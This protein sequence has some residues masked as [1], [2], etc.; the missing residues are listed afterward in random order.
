[1]E[2]RERNARQLKK[3]LAAIPAHAT[4]A[5][6]SVAFLSSAVDDATLAQTLVA[7]ANN[8]GGTIIIGVTQKGNLQNIARPE[9]HLDRVM[10]LA[11]ACDPPLI[12]P[13]P[14]VH[15]MKNRPLIVIS[16]PAD[17]PHVYNADGRYVIWENGDIAPLK[18]AALRQ[19]IFSRGETGF[20]AQIAAR[21][22]PANLNWDAVRAYVDSVPGLRHLSAEEALLKRGCLKEDG[23]HLRPTHAGLLL[24]AHDPQT[25]FSQAE[26][27]IARY[28]G[29]Q[30]TDSFL[31]ADIHGTLPEQAR[32]A[33]AFLRENIPQ[34]V[35]IAELQRTD[36]YLYPLSAV[37]EVIVN[38]LAHRDYSISGDN[39]RILMFSDRLECYSPGRLPGHVTVTNI[40][41]ERFSRNATIVQ[42]LY[43]MGFIERLGYGIDRIV[44]SIAE[45]GMPQPQF[46]ETAAG[47]KITLFAPSAAPAQKLPPVREW[48]KMGL[49]ERQ[50][51]AIGFVA[52]NG[53]I[54]NANYQTL[55]PAVSPETLRRDLADL[56]ARDILLRIG[57]KRA[58]FYI[59]K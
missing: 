10:R 48:L 20:D 4:D 23:G 5:V 49:N 17:L 7:F 43:D 44:R 40:L 53:R 16:I 8:G 52:D 39:I 15:T 55:C 1:M 14:A 12:I 47:F 42:V 26:I 2:N 11:L 36:E 41:Q 22:T 31:R 9:Q 37:R 24:F 46:E 56:V 3:I 21:A 51:K 30:M 33:E 38:A 58:T 6:S 25:W 27:T 29:V 54:T 50:I 18:G 28:A 59:L 35:H 34:A 45:R 13:S 32:R 19:L 57:E